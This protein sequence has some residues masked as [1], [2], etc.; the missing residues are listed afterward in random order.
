MIND[1]FSKT[2]NELNL[3]EQERKLIDCLEHYIDK[4]EEIFKTEE[5][6]V[7]YEYSKGGLAYDGLHCESLYRQMFYKNQLGKKCT[8]R[9]KYN[10]QYGFDINNNLI[11]TKS[12]DNDEKDGVRWG[13]SNTYHFNV[14]ENSLSLKY[15]KSIRDIGTLPYLERIELRTFENSTCTKYNS[16]TIFAGE[17]LD[18]TKYNF[19]SEYYDYRDSELYEIRLVNASVISDSVKKLFQEEKMQTIFAQG[20]LVHYRDTVRIENGVQRFLKK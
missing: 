20:P 14:N 6:I 13:V 17:F 8:E 4:Q 9:A 15:D 1:I 19:Y 12:I 11:F 5:N 3:D 18:F 7:R 2:K 10:F 16:L